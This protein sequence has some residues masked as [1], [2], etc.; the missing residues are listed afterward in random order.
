[1]RQWAEAVEA[2]RRLEVEQVGT[3]PWMMVVAV[4]GRGWIVDVN[5]QYSRIWKTTRQAP[6]PK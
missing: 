2:N 6:A 4:K 1:M 3:R 5:K